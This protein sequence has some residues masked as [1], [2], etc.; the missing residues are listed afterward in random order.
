MG[1]DLNKALR[2][3][4]EMAAGFAERLPYIVLAL[5]VFVIF[6]IAAKAI[7]RVVRTI[8]NKR[9]R[10]RNVGVVLGRLMQWLVVFLGLLIALVIALPTFKPA[11]LVQFL[12]ISSV[13]IG[14]AFRDVLQNFLAGILLLLNEPFRVGDQIKMGDLEGTVEEIETR[15]TMIRTYDNRR[16]VVPKRSSLLT[17][18]LSTQPTI[19]GGWSMMWGSDTAM[20]SRSPS[21]S[22]SRRCRRRKTSSAIPRPKC[23]S[24][25][26]ARAQSTFAPVGGLCRHDAPMHSIPATRY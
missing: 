2:G 25:N 20:T 5:L 4:N 7:R 16:I 12:G 14:F 21:A 9:R 17:R 15:A 24:M 18:L 22:C 23:W 8:S 19:N 26:L 11:Q 10:H 3:V 1:F 6:Y 13:A